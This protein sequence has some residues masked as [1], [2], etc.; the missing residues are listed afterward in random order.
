MQKFDFA[1]CILLTFNYSVLSFFLLFFLK[2][3]A[4]FFFFFCIRPPP[5]LL[6]VLGP[7]ECYM[8]PTLDAALLISSRVG[9]DLGRTSA[10]LLGVL[11]FEL[12]QS[13]SAS[14]RLIHHT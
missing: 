12:Q 6:P 5:G 2:I 8:T 7:L 9:A 10:K 13:L 14:E 3:F 11:Q 1:K 4:C